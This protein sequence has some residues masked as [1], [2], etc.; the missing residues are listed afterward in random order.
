MSKRKKPRGK[1]ELNRK[2]VRRL[3]ETETAQARG[4][5]ANTDGCGGTDACTDG[6]NDGG[7]EPVPNSYPLKCCSRVLTTRIIG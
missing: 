6:C 1:L 5:L 2:S 4:G 7:G 3:G